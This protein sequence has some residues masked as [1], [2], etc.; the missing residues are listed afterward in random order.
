MAHQREASVTQA[1]SQDRPPAIGSSSLKAAILPSPHMVICYN[2]EH[3]FFLSFVCVCVFMCLS[4][5]T[6][7]LWDACEGQKTTSVASPCLPP[8]LRQGLFACCY[9]DQPGWPT[10]FQEVSHFWSSSR[11]R[12]ARITDVCYLTSGFKCFLGV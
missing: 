12:H 3:L 8:C 4:M 11:L 1:P 10:S 6:H 9:M 5:G 7:M 2:Y